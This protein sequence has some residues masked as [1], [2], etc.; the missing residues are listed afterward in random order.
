MYVCVS[1]CIRVSVSVALW[2]KLLSDLAARARAFSFMEEDAGKN[3]CVQ[4]SAVVQIAEFRQQ[5]ASL[6]SWDVRIYHAGIDGWTYE[7]KSTK[8]NKQSS[9]FRCLLVYLDRSDLLD[10]FEMVRTQDELAQYVLCPVFRFVTSI[11]C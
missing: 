7:E 11:V 1:V 8:K 2:L 4:Q 9:T 3:G 5:S 10:L 6:S